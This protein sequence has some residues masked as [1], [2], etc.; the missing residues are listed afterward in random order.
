MTGFSP[1]GPALQRAA[2][3]LVTDHMALSAGEGLL[4]TADTSTDMAAIE[5]IMNAAANAGGRPMLAMIPKLPFQGK[6]ADPYVPD[7]LAAAMKEADAWIDLTHP[8][9][10]GSDAHDLALKAGRVRCLGA[11][12]VDGAAL[13]RLYGG[14]DLDSLFAL[15]SALDELIAKAEGK[16]CRVTDP[17]GTDV[18]FVLSKGTQGKRRQ[19]NVPGMNTVPGSVVLLPE[20]ESVRGTIRVTAAMHE[21]YTPLATPLTLE[22]DGLVRGIAERGP[23][24]AVMDRAL[25]RAGG[26]DGYGYVIHF[27]VGLN[28]AA[29]YR[30]NCF[31]EDIRV[32]G[33]NAIGLG[34]PWWEPGGG[35]N[36]PDGIIM[37]QTLVID[38]KT[39]LENGIIVG[40]P[41]LAERA[42]AVQLIYS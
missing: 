42:R 7:T 40:P 24:A 28:P 2:H 4:L 3:L 29:R 8:F 37:R 11:G 20:L 9:L 10:A 23:E 13:A 22:V 38:G 30:G 18:S 35:E 15:Q 19:A 5:A 34:K 16:E 25:R 1:H 31:I 32:P 6:L 12:G 27:S 33:A 39:I 21:Y 26:G 17:L 36:H 14:V 41:A